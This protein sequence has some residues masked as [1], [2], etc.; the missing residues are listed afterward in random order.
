MSLTS[1]RASNSLAHSTKGT[2]SPERAGSDALRAHGFRYCF[3]PLPGC[4]SPFPHG[5][6]ALSVTWEYLGLEGGP[7]GFGPGFTCPALL[8]DLPRGPSRVRLRGP[9]PVPPAFPCRSAP[10]DGDP[11]GSASSRKGRPC[12]PGG[13]K[14]GARARS[15]VWPRPLSL[16]ATRGVSMLISSPRGT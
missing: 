10:L 11:A 9:N 8:R 13:G 2:P 14:A 5:T 3:T 4:F 6:G 12:N 1:P 15:P 16:A 7:P